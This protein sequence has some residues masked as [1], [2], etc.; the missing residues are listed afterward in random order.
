M[1]PRC[2]KPEDDFHASHTPESPSGTG[3]EIHADSLALQHVRF[4]RRPTRSVS[5]ST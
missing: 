1:D 4:R 3:E 5:R 2:P